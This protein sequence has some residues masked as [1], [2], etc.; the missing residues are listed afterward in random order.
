M[1]D[2]DTRPVLGKC[3]YCDQDIYAEDDNYYGDD[4]VSINGRTM[5]YE[6]AHDYIRDIKKE[7]Q[8]YDY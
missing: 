7:A 4:I 1:T 8:L 3:G 2:E 5:H 6:C